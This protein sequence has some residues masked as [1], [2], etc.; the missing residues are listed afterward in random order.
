V[1]SD[2]EGMQHLIDSDGDIYTGDPVNEGQ[3]R[4]R[5][6][7]LSIGSAFR[8]IIGNYPK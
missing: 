5:T 8:R 3:A 7:V 1:E 4:E 6:T 2:E